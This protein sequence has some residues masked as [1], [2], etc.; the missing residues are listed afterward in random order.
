M[1]ALSELHS[2]GFV[3][4]N[5]GCFSIVCAQG[6]APTPGLGSQASFDVEAAAAAVLEQ[7]FTLDGIQQPVASEPRTCSMQHSALLCSITCLKNCQLH[8]SGGLQHLH[9]ATPCLF[10]YNCLPAQVCQLASTLSE[11]V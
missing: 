8:A 3:H 5:L 11:Y 4:G 10:L 7:R 9:P 1:Q 6:L 2:R